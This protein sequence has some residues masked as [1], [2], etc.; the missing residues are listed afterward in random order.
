MK[1]KFILAGL[2]VG[3]FF[4]VVCDANGVFKSIPSVTNKCFGGF[5]GSGGFGYRSIP[6]V[7]HL[8]LGGA[9]GTGGAAG[10]AGVGG[11][12]GAAGSSA[13]AGGSTG[14]S[15]GGTPGTGGA[16]GGSPGTGGVAT[17]GSP[18]TG[19]STGGTGGSLACGNGTLD[20]GETCDG[21]QLQSATCAS[22]GFVGG[23]LSCSS[24]CEFNAASCSGGTITPTINA[25]VTSCAAPCGVF[26][27]VITTSGLSG[28]DYVGASWDWDFNDPTSP[29]RGD[30]GFDVGH[31]YDNPG[32][33][34][35]TVRVR[36]LAGAS[37]WATKTITVSAPSYTTYYVSTSGSDSNNGL[38]T[39][40]AFATASHAFT[41][42]GANTTLLFRRGD[43]FTVSGSATQTGASI[44]GAYTDPAHIASA[45][46]IWTTGGTG[47]ITLTGT[48]PR[49][50]DIHIVSGGAGNAVQQIAATN[51]VVE[52]VEIEGEGSGC[53]GSSSGLAFYG[54]T[55]PSVNTFI[56]DNNVHDFIGYGF[57]GAADHL[58]IVGNQFLRFSGGDHG[59]R[60]IHGNLTY[61][62]YNTVVGL[63]FDTPLS[64]ITIR[65]DHT[66]ITLSHNT[67]NRLMEFTPQNTA[68]VELVQNGLAEGN[69]IADDRTT[70]FYFYSFGVT[71]KHIYVRNN[72]LAGSPV[73]FT[74][75]GMPLLPANWTDQV[76]LY[77]NT[78]YFFGTTYD[79]TFGSLL[80]TQQD[81]T[82]SITVRNNIFATGQTDTSSQ[83]AFLDTFL[84]PGGTSTEDHNLGYNPNGI[85][86]W[87]PGTG[88][89]DIVGNPHFVST[90]LSAPYPLQIG[91]TSAARN[92]GT[93][94]PARDDRMYTTRP[95][96]S[97]WDIGAYEYSP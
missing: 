51:S 1:T 65:G 23:T 30:I 61:V 7:S 88:A 47:S 57:Y 55:G 26:F 94:V 38:A 80:A 31:V 8:C 76:F 92:V 93:S 35:A 41:V 49:L 22:L 16:T 69:I 21:S 54:D 5:A 20:P 77:N 64:G 15:T 83:T 89:G 85:G 86:S 81:T 84:A 44:I 68:V 10:S 90:T 78:M 79:P 87:T 45:V 3:L 34:V 39:T 53:C 46:P 70:D 82:G 56:F 32:T 73:G 17:G 59:I 43:T 63:A 52:R 6:H 96:E 28:S 13:G 9:P 40:T 72:I 29:H 62:A 50:Q 71:A 18:G 95:K 12:A 97:I 4:T 19:G 11:H 91:S 58:A 27:E 42:Q 24:S 60:V 48:G 33:Y 74:V 14:G 37:G 75:F 36:D 67:S 25:T 66:N 2:L